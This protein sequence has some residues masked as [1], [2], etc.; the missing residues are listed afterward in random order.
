V[1]PHCSINCF[2]QN[3]SDIGPEPDFTIVTDVDFLFVSPAAV[4]CPS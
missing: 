2:G 3:D 4:I 1:Q